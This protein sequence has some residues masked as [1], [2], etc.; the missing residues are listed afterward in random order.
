VSTESSDWPVAEQ[1]PDAASLDL[2][3]GTL[4][5]TR[6]RVVVGRRVI[7]IDG[8]T[9]RGA[10]TAT[11]IVDAGGGLRVHRQGQPV[12]HE[13]LRCIPAAGGRDSK[14]GSWV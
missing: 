5:W 4:L 8:K 3:V 6:T 13:V 14:G 7:A 2:L 10:R 9:V 12:R 1:F 11:A